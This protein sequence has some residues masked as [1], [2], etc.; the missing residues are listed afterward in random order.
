MRVA[1]QLAVTPSMV[2]SDVAFML[3]G[4]TASCRLR[5]HASPSVVRIS[6]V[7]GGRDVWSP[8]RG[9]N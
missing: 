2:F 9:G 8:I 3:S 6:G 1:S 7:S 4:T 5:G